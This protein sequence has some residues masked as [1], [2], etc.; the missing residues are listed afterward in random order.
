MEEL[1]S[2]LIYRDPIFRISITKP[3]KNVLVF[4]LWK[5]LCIVVRTREFIILFAGD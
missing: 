1:K 5:K 2:R 4:R 3:A